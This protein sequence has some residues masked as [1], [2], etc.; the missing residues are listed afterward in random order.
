MHFELELCGGNTQG[1]TSVS[2]SRR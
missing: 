1:R 2:F